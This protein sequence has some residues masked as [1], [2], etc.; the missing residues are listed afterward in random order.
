MSKIPYE[1]RAEVKD[2]FMTLQE[3]ADLMGMSRER[4]RQ[5][6]QNGLRKMKKVL[7]SKGITAE[8]FISTLRYAKPI[9]PSEASDG[10]EYELMY[11]KED[12]D[13]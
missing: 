7:A 3:I 10:S 8:D 2:P 9:K 12:K 13:E 6:E 4:V 5:I 11:D 1:K